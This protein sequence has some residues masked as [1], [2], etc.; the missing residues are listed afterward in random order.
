MPAIPD[1][2]MTCGKSS[3]KFY[4]EKK[5]IEAEREQLSLSALRDLQTS[6][7]GRNKKRIRLKKCLCIVWTNKNR[8]S[9][10]NGFFH[11]THLICEQGTGLAVKVSMHVCLIR[12]TP[13]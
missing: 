5:H 1:K 11:Q 8:E 12:G 4:Y 3:T 9:R 2:G 6:L 10:L 13:S 7:T